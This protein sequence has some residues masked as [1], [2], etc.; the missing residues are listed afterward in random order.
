[1]M[2]PVSFGRLALLE[3]RLRRAAVVVLRPH[4]AVAAD[5]DVEALATAR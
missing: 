4:V 3:R 5:L 2:V 1:M